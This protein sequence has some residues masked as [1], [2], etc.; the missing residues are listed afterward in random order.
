[1]KRVALILLSYLLWAHIGGHASA[2]VVY[3]S[4]SFDSNITDDAGDPY[5]AAWV[6]AISPNPGT[7]SWVNEGGNGV[8]HYTPTANARGVRADL[9]TT[10]TLS[11]LNK[12][13]SFDLRVRQFD[14]ES[15]VNNGFRIYFINSVAVASSGTNGYVFGSNWGTGVFD[16]VFEATGANSAVVGTQHIDGGDKYRITGTNW[17]SVNGQ[18]E[19]VNS[20]QLRFTFGLDGTNHIDS[21]LVTD[22]LPTF[23]FDRIMLLSSSSSPFQQFRIDDVNVLS[24]AVPEPS[25]LW[26]WGCGALLGWWRYRARFRG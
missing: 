1:M 14:T 13:F 4:D 10:I 18:I 7:V 8:M 23:T 25:S 6:T 16:G 19:Y 22:S 17:H 20:T 12:F 15:T 5:D 26:L 24:S 3:L 21:V 11:P 9:P 2:T